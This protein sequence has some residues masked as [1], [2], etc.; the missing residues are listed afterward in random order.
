MLW[1]AETDPRLFVV[2]RQLA[3]LSSTRALSVFVKINDSDC[4]RPSFAVLLTSIHLVQHLLQLK[5]FICS[6]SRVLDFESRLRF[7]HSLVQATE[8][9]RLLPSSVENL[10]IP[11]LS[12]KHSFL[13]DQLLNT[14][15]LAS[16]KNFQFDWGQQAISWMTGFE[17]EVDLIISRCGM[18]EINTGYSP[19]GLEIV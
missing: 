15:F 5:T 11:F 4:D 16:L 10:S 18:R 2:H 9:L 7:D 14:T 8:A 1:M 17:E 19:E 6:L 12:T 3:R 13:A